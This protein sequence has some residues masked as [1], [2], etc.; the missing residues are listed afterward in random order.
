MAGDWE[1]EEEVRSGGGGGGGGDEGWL[2]ESDLL[3]QRRLSLAGAVA[4]L[5]INPPP[6]GSP[7]VVFSLGR[8]ACSL[9]EAPSA[10]GHSRR[11][12]HLL[13]QGRNAAHRQLR[14]EARSWANARPS[15][16]EAVQPVPSSLDERGRPAETSNPS[17][18]SGNSLHRIRHRQRSRRLHPHQV[19]SPLQT[20]L[21]ALSKVTLLRLD[22]TPAADDRSKEKLGTLNRCAGTADAGSCLRET[23][24]HVFTSFTE[25]ATPKEEPSSFV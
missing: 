15:P 23:L 22:M 12:L 25:F 17:R 8:T 9:T 7:M 13:Q 18:L 10:S 3:Q 14:T 11:Q 24:S 21:A 6:D 5:L 4:S 20:E 1:E 2:G 19:C 16:A